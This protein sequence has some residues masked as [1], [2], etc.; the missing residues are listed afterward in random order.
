M[1]APSDNPAR[2]VHDEQSQ[3]HEENDEEGTKQNAERK[4]RSQ[5][6]EKRRKETLVIG[7]PYS[8]SFAADHYLLRHSRVGGNPNFS[9]T[10]LDSRLRRNDVI[11]WFPGLFV[12]RNAAGQKKCLPFII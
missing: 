2:S 6:A 10:N 7:L 9:Q 8:I 12:F 11:L 4:E 5:E 3:R 1:K